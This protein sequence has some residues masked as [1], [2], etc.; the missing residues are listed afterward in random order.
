[1]F[2]SASDQ[3]ALPESNSKIRAG[4]LEDS[5]R[6]DA[7][8]VMR[9]L[10]PWG[11]AVL[12]HGAVVATAMLAVWITLR[13]VPTEEIITP[14]LGSVPRITPLTTAWEKKSTRHGGCR[15]GGI[16]TTR[17]IPNP[18]PLKND[19]NTPPMLGFK[20]G[21]ESSSAI[22]KGIGTGKSTGITGTIFVVGTRPKSVAFVIDASGSMLDTMPLVASELKRTLR[23]LDET[24]TFTVIFYQDGQ[25][26][27]PLSP[28]LKQASAEN[29]TR[30]F[31]WLDSNDLAPAGLSHPLAAIEQGL[32]YKPQL[33]F[34]LSDNIT[35]RGRFEIDQATLLKQ[36]DAAN[37][38]KT[39]INTLQFIYPD[40]LERQG[41]T[42]TMKLIAQRSG[43]LYRFIGAA[44]LGLD[45]SSEA[46]S[47]RAIPAP[48]P[49]QGEGWGEGRDAQVFNRH[50]RATEAAAGCVRRPSPGRADS[51]TLSLEGRGN[52]ATE[53]LARAL[54]RGCAQF[55]GGLVPSPPVCW[56]RGLG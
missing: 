38:G 51:A 40:P 45:E 8:A 55:S 28:G 37:A 9:D 48:S 47:A 50:D 17:E 30:M 24:Q 35:G 31:D 18:L 3:Y 20:G 54:P 19:F 43:G 56:G 53:I 49:F 23:Q 25:A 39:K 14:T 13:P 1:M 46:K 12:L 22:F 36:I 4:K 16:N 44:D 15:P 52:R 32:R 27:E 6:D 5:D 33:M 11:I 2:K 29:L 34:M 10:V 7:A 26:V 42:G 41:M 21:S